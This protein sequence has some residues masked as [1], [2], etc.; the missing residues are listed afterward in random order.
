MSSQDI[1]QGRFA[2]LVGYELTDWREDEVEVRLQ[3]GEQH[4][5]RSGVLHGGA[6]TTLIDA[7]CGY[8]GCYS[9]DPQKPR[10]AMTLSLTCNFVA[11]VQ[12]GDLL[13][14]K[15][16]RTGGGRQIF[17]S[18]CKVEDQAS[19]LVAEASGVFKYRRGSEPGASS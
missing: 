16:R 14:A 19:R 11:A 4:M 9:P 8:S 1:L 15:A 18:D 3:V 2:R 17:F 13:I 10:R 12:A 5:N 6:M 7:A